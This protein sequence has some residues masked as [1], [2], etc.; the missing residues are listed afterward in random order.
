[1]LSFIEQLNAF[2]TTTDVTIGSATCKLAVSA[3]LG[4]AIGFERKR[5][6]QIAGSRTFALISMGATL[7]MLVSCAIPQ[8]FSHLANGGDPARIAAQ[9][10]SGIGFLGAGAI[11]QTKAS[12]RGLTTAAGIWVSAGIGLAVGIG[13]YA[14]AFIAM[15]F[16]LITLIVIN[17][18]ENK[19]NFEWESHI[20]AIELP[21]IID[22]IECY[23]LVFEQ[24]A[25]KM[26]EWYIDVDYSKP[27]SSIKFVVQMRENADILRLFD[28]MQKLHTTNNISLQNE[29]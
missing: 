16:I 8:L 6:G 22:S 21:L 18:I 10:I 11:I 24:H 25:V 26:H 12:V 19:M 14:I 15:I 23:R 20:I 5:K 7:A 27:L 28:D 13:L 4:G 2:M 17:N 9:V 1:M 29:I 3:L